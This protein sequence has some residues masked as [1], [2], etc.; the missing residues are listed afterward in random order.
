MES[1]II[2]IE[3]KHTYVLNV[4]DV[5]F[6]EPEFINGRWKNDEKSIT[7]VGYNLNDCD[8]NIAT[9]ETIYSKGK[10]FNINKKISL[11]NIDSSRKKSIWVV[12]NKTTRSEF[13][14]LHDTIHESIIIQAFRLNDNNE[15]IEN[16]IIE[17]YIV[18]GTNTISKKFEVIGKVIN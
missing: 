11:K 7:E 13:K 3:P 4:N 16:E 8:I 17:F 9:I 18:G 15:I 12:K 1:D 2:S 14:G 5:F 6:G 10:I